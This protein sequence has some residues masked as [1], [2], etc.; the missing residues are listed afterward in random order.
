MYAVAIIDMCAGG[1]FA[2]GEGE[3]SMGGAT[4]CGPCP[5]GWLC[6]NGIGYPCQAPNYLHS[7]PK[8]GTTACVPCPFGHDCSGGY[9]TPCAAGAFSS[10]G[11]EGCLLCKPGTISSECASDGCTDCPAGK[12]SNYARTGAVCSAAVQHYEF[13]CMQVV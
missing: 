1:Q 7:N 5:D 13:L 2:C 11:M 3:Y 12:T 9:A 4:E 6:E 8:T 10:I